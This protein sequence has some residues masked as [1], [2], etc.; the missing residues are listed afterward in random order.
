SAVPSRASGVSEL[1]DA[2]DVWLD[3][4]SAGAILLDSETLIRGRFQALDSGIW[5]HIEAQSPTL[6][7]FTGMVPS[8]AAA[9][10]PRN[11]PARPISPSALEKLAACPLSWFY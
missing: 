6:T 5:A 3:A 7:Q 11:R 2:R 4:L 1:L 8:A 9:L 10:D